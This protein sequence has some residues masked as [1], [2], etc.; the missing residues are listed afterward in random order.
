MVHCQLEVV[1][2]GVLVL[3]HV[4]PQDLALCAARKPPWMASRSE[5]GAAVLDE[6]RLA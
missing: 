4:I 2:A 5:M 1:V 6:F 3:F